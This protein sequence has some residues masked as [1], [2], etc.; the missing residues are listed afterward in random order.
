MLTR[1][2]GSTGN[3]ALLLLW[4]FSPIFLSPVVAT[5][6][7]QGKRAAVH[8]CSAALPTFYPRAP[9]EIR[10]DPT[11][12]CSVLRQAASRGIEP[13][14]SVARATKRQRRLKEFPAKWEQKCRKRTRKVWIRS[15]R[16]AF[17]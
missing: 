2:G 3:G 17:K 10:P 16:E 4:R 15:L 12:R 5:A 8:R 7:F 14:R 13:K 9:A 11:V 1:D 6:Y